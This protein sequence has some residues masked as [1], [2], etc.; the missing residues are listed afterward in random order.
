MSGEDEKDP[1]VE[2]AVD[3]L[4][5]EYVAEG[6]DRLTG[7]R[8]AIAAFRDRAPDAT[9]SLRT[10]FHRLA[11]SGAAYGFPDISEAAREAELWLATHPAMDADSVK[12]LEHTLARL[13]DAFARA[14]REIESGELP[15]A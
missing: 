12:R 6:L 14:R 13:E 10:Q 15:G 1:E 3:E 9:A 11:G 2:Q 4:R 8:K 7:L 5:R